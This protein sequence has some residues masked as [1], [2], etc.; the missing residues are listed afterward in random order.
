MKVHNKHMLQ[1]H[2]QHPLEAIADLFQWQKK[3]N[4]SLPLEELKPQLDPTTVSMEIMKHNQ[5]QKCKCQQRNMEIN[6]WWV[7]RPTWLW[8]SNKTMYNASA[9]G[10]NLSDHKTESCSWWNN[11]GFWDHSSTSLAVKTKYLLKKE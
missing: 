8:F 4:H 9:H 6:S 2:K 10:L 7:K 5:I 3:D 11:S 1:H